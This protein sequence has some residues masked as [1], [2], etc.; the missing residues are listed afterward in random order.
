MARFYGM[1]GFWITEEKTPGAWIPSITEKP[2]YGDVVENI[3]KWE[4]SDNINDDF[5]ISNKI[6]ILADAF[7]YQNI[8]AMKYVV[9]LGQK[10]KIRQATISH[11]RI[12][13][14][15]GDVYHE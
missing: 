7:A 8:G 9:Y 14:T 5:N 15:L 11:P 2:Y 6:S 10:W 1:I 3:R 13:L 4:T 12:I